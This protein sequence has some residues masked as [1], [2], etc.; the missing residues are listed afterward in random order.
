M[1]NL[2][3]LD[4]AATTKTLAEVYRL[5]EENNANFFNPSASYMHALSA[6]NLLEDARSKITQSLHGNNG[7]LVFTSSATESNNMVAE[8][9]H[10]RAGQAVIISGAEHPSVFNSFKRLEK[11]GVIVKVAPLLS[12][13]TIDT[14]AFKQMLSSEVA[15]VSIIHVSNE[16]GAI[17]D[18]KKLC[19]ITKR[20]N[21]KIIFH[22]DG[23]QAVG[24]IRVNIDSL[25]VDLY[26][27][28]AHKIYAPRGIAGL[29][30]KNGVVIDALLEGGGQEFGLR[31]STENT[32]GAIALSYCVEKTVMEQEENYQK[33]LKLKQ[34]LISKLQ[35]SGLENIVVNSDENCCPYIVSIS[36]LGI[37]GEVLMNALESDNIIV[38]TGSACSAGAVTP[39]HVISAI[40]GEERAKSAV[41][42]TFGKYN[43]PEEVDRAVDVLKQIVSQTRRDKSGLD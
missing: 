23:V 40:A 10:L 43:T 22:S 34:D 26:T 5:V 14:N 24:K 11:K 20:Y 38:S 15:L 18:I 2:Y 36:F 4:N 27:F 30:I 9:I 3:Y 32:D 37:K 31:S 13:G 7:R 1:E 19:E 21:S 17:N 25:G 42:F 33:M 41:R 28:S 29:W 6:R 16:T 12:N 39:S 8:G 35:E